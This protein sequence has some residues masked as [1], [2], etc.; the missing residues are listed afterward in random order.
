MSKA[1]TAGGLCSQ[2]KLASGDLGIGDEPPN[3]EGQVYGE[4]R[5]RIFQVEAADLCDTLHAVQERI[6]VNVQF[7]RRLAQ[8]AVLL[9][10]CF[11]GGDKFVIGIALVGK[12]TERFAVEAPQFGRFQQQREQTIDTQIAEIE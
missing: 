6:T 10:K 5:F 12:F 11:E 2:K 1:P 7:V 8:I 9:E 4:A 3:L